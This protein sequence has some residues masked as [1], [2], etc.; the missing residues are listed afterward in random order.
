MFGSCSCCR[1]GGFIGGS[2][3]IRYPGRL[4]GCLRCGH[5]ESCHRIG[6]Y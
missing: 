6:W 5:P 3:C 2:G 4:G 1:S